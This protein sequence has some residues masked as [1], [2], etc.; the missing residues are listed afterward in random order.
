[1]PG[2]ERIEE[3]FEKYEEDISTLSEKQKLLTQRKNDLLQVLRDNLNKDGNDILDQFLLKYYDC[4]HEEVKTGFVF[5]FVLGASLLS[6]CI[7]FE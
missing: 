2:K 7:S 5:G 3:L 1:M 6:E 4:V